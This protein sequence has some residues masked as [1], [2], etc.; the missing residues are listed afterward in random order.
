MKSIFLRTT[1]LV[2]IFLFGCSD[3]D[4]IGTQLPWELN[5]KGRVIGC[6]DF[7]VNQIL[8]NDHLNITISVSGAGK[9]ILNLTSEYKTFSLPNDD[10]ITRI[11]VM[12]IAVG[13]YYCNDAIIQ[14]PKLVSLWN[15]VSGDIK[16][17]IFNDENSINEDPYYITI[18]L[19]N[20]FFENKDN[21]QQRF[22]PSLTFDNVLVGWY[23]G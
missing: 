7:F 10:L 19:E 18:V 3:N 20:I 6:G 9:N 16:I 8:D 11:S 2:S 5:F 23:P 4:G 14:E 17:A 12:D 22:I 1:I 15:A 13:Q 21:G